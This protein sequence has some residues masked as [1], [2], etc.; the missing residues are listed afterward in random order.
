MNQTITVANSYVI[1]QKI[2]SKACVYRWGIYPLW[3]ILTTTLFFRSPIPIDETRYL[4]VA[5]EMWLRDDHLVPY[6]NGLPY[7]HK[8]P[9]LFW[10][11]ETGWALLG[12]ANEWWPRLVGPI[13]ALFNLLL[14]R[15]LASKL[16]PE[17]ALV[18]LKAP[19]VLIGTLLWTLFATSTMFDILLTCCVLLAMIGLYDAANHSSSTGWRHFAVAIGLGLLTKGPV[20][21]LHLLPTALLVFIWGKSCSIRKTVWYGRLILAI[22]AGALIGLAWAVPAALSGG[23]DYAS[24]ILWQQTADRTINTKIHARSFSWYL[25]FVPLMIFPWLTWPRLWQN[26]RLASIKQDNGLRFCLV[27]LLS[28]LLIFSALPSKQI[29]YLIPIL[30]AFALICARILCHL[31]EQRNLLPELTPALFM[32]LIGVFL[33]LLPKV[34]GLSTL[35]WVQLVEPYWGAGVFIIALS[36]AGLVVHF[37]KLSVMSLATA[38]VGSAFIG[39]IFFFQYTGLQYNLRQAALLIKSYHERQIPTAFVGDYQGQF[40]FLG[41]LTQPLTIITPDSASAWAAQHP[42][43]YLIYLEKNQPQQAAYSQPHR[44]HWL[45]F[46]TAEHA[47]STTQPKT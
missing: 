39:F 11:F 13:C 45:I 26:L 10:L 42:N 32:A 17:D 1:N 3:L 7:S 5:W 6:L 9:L 43:G 35:Q 21:L 27:W 31:D 38:L 30:P 14:I 22:L 46:R 23:D 34:P 20:I 24:A 29:H 36:L 25:P 33:V 18:A 4:S 19:W 15:H 37:R 47:L 2:L 12:E 8:P 16:W 44:E 41:R 40:H 28:T